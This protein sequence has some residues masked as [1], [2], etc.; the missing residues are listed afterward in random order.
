MPTLTTTTSPL[1]ESA[2]WALELLTGTPA[3]VVATIAVAGFGF[4]LLQGRIDVR[5]GAAVIIGIF[6]VFGAPAIASALMSALRP[7]PQPSMATVV[8]PAIPVVLTSPSGSNNPAYDPYAG[9]ALP[10][11]R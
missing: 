10:T 5:R 8:T 11:N 4:A 9:A 3:V 7:P 6:I 2:R 1:I